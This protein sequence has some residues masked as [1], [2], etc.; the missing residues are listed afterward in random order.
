V[1]KITTDERS[2]L[3][4]DLLTSANF[5]AGTLLIFCGG[6]IMTGILALL[7][8]VPQNLKARTDRL[9]HGLPAQRRIARRGGDRL[10]GGVRTTSYPSNSV[11]RVRETAQR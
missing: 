6:L 11:A 7:P 10:H 5:I 3:D 9:H 2:F 8:T 1:H 4:R